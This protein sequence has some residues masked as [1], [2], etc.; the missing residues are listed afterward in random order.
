M[1][2]NGLPHIVTR[3]LWVPPR[4]EIRLHNHFLLELFDARSGRKEAEAE[5]E[6]VVT[7]RGRKRLAETGYYHHRDFHGACAVGTGT[8][9]PSPTDITM[10]A[11]LKAAAGRAISSQ[12]ASPETYSIAVGDWWRRHKFYFPENVANYSLTEVGLL[13]GGT[14]SG[15]SSPLAGE[16]FNTTT[17]LSDS[18][19]LNTRALF[20]DA[21]GDPIS[22]TK[23]NT[24]VMVI[25]A[26]I[27]FQRGGVDAGMRL[28]DN[29]FIRMAEVGSGQSS[30]AWSF[31]DYGDWYLGQGSGPLNNNN[32]ALSGP[33]LAR[34]S[35]PG[36]AS[37][38]RKNDLFWSASG[39]IDTNGNSSL[40]PAEK[41]YTTTY[42]QD[43]ELNEGNGTFS[44]VL[45]RMLAGSGSGSGTG[46]P[47][48]SAVHIVFP[49]GTV[50]GT[51]VTKDNQ[52]KMRQYLELSW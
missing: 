48:D 51:S 35:D 46:G 21:N 33:Q 50:G 40:R 17:L 5:A 15:S 2:R 1:K 9:A 13:Q 24:Q 28:L 3:D 14:G 36:G 11:N 41:P 31:F 29:Y 39:W 8:N 20:R 23:S 10:G 12:I 38:N 22:V 34:K 16:S 47:T 4:A 7:N 52:S 26:T 6:N 19:P 32:T 18:I 25:T 42:S 49:C 37:V 45:V 27:Y 30:S 44:E 43:W